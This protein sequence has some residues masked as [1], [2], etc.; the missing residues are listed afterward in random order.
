MCLST[1][2]RQRIGEDK[3][4][5]KVQ[6]ADRTLSS[7]SSGPPFLSNDCEKWPQHSSEEHTCTHAGKHINTHKHADT[8]VQTHTPTHTLIH[9]SRHALVHTLQLFLKMRSYQ[10][11]LFFFFSLRHKKMS[12]DKCLPAEDHIA[13]AP[14]VLIVSCH[15]RGGGSDI[16]PG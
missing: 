9:P 15:F 6:R 13:E 11:I 2:L 7:K 5:P 12:A 4:R 8:R 16:H 10:L 1:G 3:T 14:Q